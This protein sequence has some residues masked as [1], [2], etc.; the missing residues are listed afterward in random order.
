MWQQHDRLLCQRGNS[1]RARLEGE[2]QLGQWCSRQQALCKQNTCMNTTRMPEQ[3]ALLE[4]VLGEGAGGVVAALEAI[5]RW[6]PSLAGGGRSTSR[7]RSGWHR[8]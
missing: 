5:P 8:W 7:G 6:R 4:V 2:Q 1:Q 3:V